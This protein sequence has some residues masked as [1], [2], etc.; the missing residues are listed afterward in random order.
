MHQHGSRD[1]LE[2]YLG[3]HFFN[4]LTRYFLII[5]SLFSLHHHST[6]VS[7]FWF[8]GLVIPSS[9]LCWWRTQGWNVQ[10]VFKYSCCW[11]SINLDTHICNYMYVRQVH[12]VTMPLATLREKKFY[13]FG[14]S[15]VKDK[16]GYQT[17]HGPGRS[18]HYYLNNREYTNTYQMGRNR[19]SNDQPRIWRGALIFQSYYRFIEDTMAENDECT[20][21]E[22][23]TLLTTKF[24]LENMIYSKRTI[25]IVCNELGWTFNTAQTCL[26]YT[27]DAADE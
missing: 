20:P 3:G 13:P 23:Q 24:W 15:L 17:K 1:D 8:K 27:S 9:S 2:P 6:Y 12:L 11:V 19:I 22:L 5:H 16:D 10:F 18:I 25:A 4:P 7:I 14:S 21:S 26:L